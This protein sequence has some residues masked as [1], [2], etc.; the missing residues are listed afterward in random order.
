MSTGEHA[1]PGEQTGLGM[2]P[3]LREGRNWENLPSEGETQKQ[4]PRSVLTFLVL[5][6]L[7]FSRT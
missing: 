7:C 5:L 2:L 1:G 3:G 4:I 6:L